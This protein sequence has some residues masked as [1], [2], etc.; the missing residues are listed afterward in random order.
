M[1]GK[2]PRSMEIRRQPCCLLQQP[3]KFFFSFPSNLADSQRQNRGFIPRRERHLTILD[4]MT[5]LSFPRK[6]NDINDGNDTTASRSPESDRK[7]FSGRF[8]RKV[9]DI[10]FLDR[11]S[12]Y[13]I[14]RHHYNLYEFYRIL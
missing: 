10:C 4:D 9:G 12:S 8:S 5:G 1:Y 13:G 6:S 14:V 7:R 11:I 2:S 3:N